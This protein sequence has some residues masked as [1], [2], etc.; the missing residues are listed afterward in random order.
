MKL[1]EKFHRTQLFFLCLLMIF[2]TLLCSVV[3]A[4]ED[5]DREVVKVGF[6]AFDGYHMIDENGNRSG[7]GYDFLRL[8]ARY[9]NVDYEYVGYEKSWDDMLEMLRDGRIDMVSSAQVTK[10]RLQEFAFSKPIG[11]SSAMLTIRSGNEEI[12][13]GE[14]DTY[15]GIR[16]GLLE[17]NS[18]NEDLERFASEKGFTYT[19]VYYEVYTDL[20]DALQNGQVD[21]MLTSSLRK[22]ENEWILD[23]F[24]THD[25]AVIVRKDDTALLEKINYAIEQLNAVE[26]DWQNDLKNLYY[27]HL[28][29]RN[30]NFTSEEQELIRRYKDGAKELIV[31]ACTDKKPY[32]YVENGEAK[33]IL[34]DYF[35]E[36]ANYVGIPYTVV[37]PTDRAE[38]Q[39]WCEAETPAN[40][41]LDGRFAYEQQAEDMGKALT[42]TYVTMRLAQVTRRDFDGEIRTLAVATSQ[43]LFG[44]EDGLAPNAERLTVESRED[45]MKAVL[46]GKADATFVYLY[47]AQQFVNQDERG[48]LTYTML[49]EPTYDY[50]VAFASSA[51]HAL[52]GIF[53]KAIYAMPAG[54]FENIAAEY[55]SYKA[56]DIDALTWIRIHPLHTLAICVIIFILCILVVVLFERQKAIKIEKQRSAQLQELAA[57]ADSSNRAKTMFLNN[58]SHDIRTPMNAIIGFTSLAASHL[59]NPQRVK[60]YLQ[61]ISVSSEHLLSLINDVLD[62]S[63]IESGKVKIDEQPLNLP[64]LM[65]DI[66][67]MVQPTITSKQ[68][69]FVI[70]TVDVR[71]EDI[72]TDKLRLKQV[73]LNILSN[74]VKFNKMNGMISLRI[75]QLKKAPAGYAG[76]EF[77]I[78]DTGIGMKPAFKEHIFDAFAREETATVSG[79]PGTGLGMT[80]VKNIVDMM[81]GTISVE[82]QE[83][84][85]TE[86]TVTLNFKLSG[87]PVEYEKLEQLQGL[88]VLVADDDTDTCL[89]VSSMLKDIGMRPEW[90]VSGKE[91]VVRAK[92][93]YENGDEFAAYI[94]D[95]LM[96]DMNGIETVRRIRSVIG[97]EKPIII[98][99]AYDWADIE[100]EAREAGVTAF[101][102]KPL[103]M[104]ELRNILSKPF[105]EEIPVEEKKIDFAGKKILLV[106]DNQLNQEIAI[107]LLE[108]MGLKVETANDGSVA[109][110][111]ME[112]AVPGQYDMIFMD[113]Q[114]PFMDGYEATRHIR[115]LSDAETASIPIVAM[116]ANAFSSDYEKAMACGMNGYL[117]KPIDVKRIEE[118][119][120]EVLK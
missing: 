25:F 105:R 84:I 61:K 58:M 88:R 19:P 55:T 45:A 32:A 5:K 21:A 117:T 26:G 113:I 37:V 27:Q 91:A 98:L 22:T 74:S 60:E 107:T 109:V 50:H 78:R 120:Q 30:L 110:E 89:N 101:C 72:I 14:Y 119:L 118:V 63:R 64:E 44:I 53:T 90:T 95:W 82:S 75:K 12:I 1:R 66:R 100:T 114:M 59:D 47:T 77:I 62:M 8:A 16:I 70:D 15:D 112:K 4:S 111:I 87:E 108:Q 76:Y 81:G 54:T 34:F 73:L 99:T 69:N 23:M 48:L 6:F 49:E 43:G 46:D 104:S 79:I 57:M 102:A 68:L 35:K 41:F 80:I 51:N 65:H 24:D 103:F 18:R 2:S 38:Y 36:L 39:Q 83:G 85:G 42:E 116:T 56:G 31:S 17:N 3:Y 13:G 10:E 94:I 28:D 9:I 33:G 96:P 92:Y 29:E 93:A 97:D 52:A 20:E 7:Y 11:S 86:F 67:T 71:D 106:E 40:V 115:K